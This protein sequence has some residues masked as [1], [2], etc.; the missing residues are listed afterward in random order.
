MQCEYTFSGHKS[1]ILCLEILPNERLVSGSG[2]KCFK[3]WDLNANICLNTF[4]SVSNP[5]SLSL[6]NNKYLLSGHEN[7]DVLVWS[8]ENMGIV[9]SIT[10]HSSYI[11]DFTLLNNN[12]NL[13]SYS[14]QN[15]YILVTNT[16]T[17]K[18]IR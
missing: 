13:F 2:D 12:E 8:L 6:F 3:I 7:G 1:D 18:L 10:N 4:Y 14:C 16:E 11:L 9:R 15:N 17:N 5:W